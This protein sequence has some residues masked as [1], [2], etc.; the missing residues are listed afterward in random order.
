MASRAS[1]PP[2]ESI[3]PADQTDSSGMA[4]TDGASP[5]PQLYKLPVRPRLISPAPNRRRRC[6]SPKSLLAPPSPP[7]PTDSGYGSK[8]AGTPQNINENKKV[9]ATLFSSLVAHAYNI[10]DGPS[11]SDNGGQTDSDERVSEDVDLF[12]GGSP[13]PTTK[14][15]I[16]HKISTPTRPS[17]TTNVSFYLEQPMVK[18]G[19]ISAAVALQKVFRGSLRLPDRFVPVR[20]SFIPSS[21]K[22]K[23]TKP[24]GQMSTAER[25]LRHERE[26]PDAFCLR[27]RRNGSAVRTGSD[28]RNGSAVFDPL[29]L[30]ARETYGIVREGFRT[31]LATIP[32]REGARANSGSVWAV[33][34]VAP[35]I[36]SVSI[37][38]GDGRGNFALRGTNTRFFSC[39]FLGPDLKPDEEAEQ[40]QGRL[41]AAL[42]IDRA[43]RILDFD[44]TG[45][46]HKASRKKAPRWDRMSPRKTFWNGAQWIND[47]KPPNS[48]TRVLPCSPFRV[49]DAPRLRDD[50]Y[51]SVLAYSPA[52]H[53]LAVGL[54]STLYTW[55]EAAGVNTLD[56]QFSSSHITSVAFSSCG[57]GKE[58]IAYGTSDK[59]VCLMALY[60]RRPRMELLQPDPVTN[61]NHPGV[62]VETEDLLVGDEKGNI[63][64]L[65][66]E[67]PFDWEVARDNW[68]GEVRVVHMIN[69]H[70]QQICGL[71]WSKMGN[72]FASGSND[73]NCCL[74]DTEEV[75]GSA[76]SPTMTT[77]GSEEMNATEQAFDPEPRYEP[78]ET[79]DEDG[80][81][82]LRHPIIANPLPLG[83]EKHRWPHGAAVKAIAFCPWQEGLVATGGGSYDRC[84]H[85]FH[86]TTG[87]ALATIAVASQVTGLMWSTTRREIAATFGYPQPDHPYRIA[88]FAWP[89]CRQIAA[90]PWEGKHRALC[91]VQY[92][93]EP[94]RSSIPWKERSRQR[95]SGQRDE[96]Q[97]M[98]SSVNSNRGGCVV[99][100]ASDESVKFYEVWPANKKTATG[101]VGM[102]GGSDIL[103]SLEGIYKG[104]GT[105]R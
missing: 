84:I 50:F 46:P 67:W 44:F 6:A 18:Q 98:L 60:E 30:E 41:A 95:R 28:L 25:L 48:L 88:V 55:S 71:A 36:N 53:T 33:G 22:F 97:D 90:I 72:M 103:E 83:S 80:G 13:P 73:N 77:R 43:L 11:C 31:A 39:D 7:S 52:S 100:A 20:D 14:D 70:R 58:I 54:G 47:A 2:G 62:N 69:A 102:L 82:A 17:T 3:D 8:A 38:V 96:L 68:K 81:S 21:E 86:A 19:Q 79:D 51:C 65:I 1:E 66:V 105:I 87:V 32:Q 29:I 35:D 12:P 61:P 4:M 85:F 93:I 5:N 27:P 45:S 23:T 94:P 63:Y 89:S 10:Y 64:Y 104:G 99:V 59:T 37:A 16:S 15:S 24:V 49:L 57:G 34:G 9:A 26:T 92:P 78:E 40:H 42:E 101:G 74:F 75:L 76:P 56:N 91:A